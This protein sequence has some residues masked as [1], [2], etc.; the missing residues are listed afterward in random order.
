[1]KKKI[2]IGIVFI[3]II[4][5]IVV[6]FSYINK[7]YS[8]NYIIARGYEIF[9][10]EYCDCVFKGPELSG[11]AITSHKC[12]I[13]EK[14]FEH[15]STATPIICSSCAEITGRSQECGKLIR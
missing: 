6:L 9:G 14:E 11:C 15:P 5:L 12:K 3:A 2:I 4:A 1:M 10:E 13:C 7:I 8:E